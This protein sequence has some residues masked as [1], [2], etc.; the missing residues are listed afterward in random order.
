MKIPYY[1]LGH[2]IDRR[3]LEQASDAQRALQNA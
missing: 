2:A 1:G 3:G